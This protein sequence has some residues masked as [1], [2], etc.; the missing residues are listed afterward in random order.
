MT[1]QPIISA[2][3]V[4]AVSF[5]GLMLVEKL[6]HIVTKNPDKSYRWGFWAFSIL[7]ALYVYIENIGR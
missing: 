6:I 3:I 4:F 5:G 1:I 2:L 7:I